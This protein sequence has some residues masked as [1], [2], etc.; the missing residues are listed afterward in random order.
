MIIESFNL[1][2]YERM[3]H[4][5]DNLE[6]NIEGFLEKD[7][8]ELFE[9]ALSFEDNTIINQFFNAFEFWHQTIYHNYNTQY[10]WGVAS[11]LN[12]FLM[13]LFEKT[14]V[15]LNASAAMNILRIANCIMY[16]IEGEMKSQLWEVVV[17]CC[18][19]I[20]NDFFH[21]SMN[22]WLPVISSLAFFIKDKQCERIYKKLS[23]LIISIYYSENQKRITINSR[24]LHFVAEKIRVTLAL[25]P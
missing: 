7:L 16:K 3:L 23:S 11:N 6:E 9:F 22:F 5:W 2:F 8:F 15:Y 12:K 1:F 24:F 20:E 13:K 25:S 10:T 18:K 19:I 14:K 21:I 4:L 17:N